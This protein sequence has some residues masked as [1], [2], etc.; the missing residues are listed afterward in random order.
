MALHILPGAGGFAVCGSSASE[1][2]VFAQP[3]RGT[4]IRY[5]LLPNIS[6]ERLADTAHFGQQAVAE[7]AELCQRHSDRVPFVRVCPP[8]SM[9]VIGRERE[10]EG[11]SAGALP[12]LGV[13]MC[14]PCPARRS[15]A[16]EAI[17]HDE[18]TVVLEDDDRRKAVATLHRLGILRHGGIVNVGTG[19]RAC[20]EADRFEAEL[21]DSILCRFHQHRASSPNFDLGRAPCTIT[22]HDWRRDIA[23]DPE[24]GRF[25][26]TC[27]VSERQMKR[28]TFQKI[29]VGGQPAHHHNVYVVLLDPAVGRLKKVRAENPKRDPKKPCV[30]VG[31]TGLTPEERFANHKAGIKDA[32]LVKRYGIRLLPEF[33]A[34]LN[35]MPFEEAVQMEKDLAEDLRRAGYTVTGGH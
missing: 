13:K 1:F 30:Y 4:E 16:V 14:Q 19:L 23:L 35:P 31:M 27:A 5:Q 29:R 3:G 15:K 34:H 9:L 26:A 24:G 10:F 8:E 28:R 12:N 11:V 6:H 32:S 18:I 7:I 20:V 33:Y 25:I 2:S 22:A 17:G 21:A